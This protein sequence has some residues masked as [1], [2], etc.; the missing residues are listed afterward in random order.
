[1]KLDE[2]R[3]RFLAIAG[4][5]ATLSI[6]GCSSQDPNRE[7]TVDHQSTP[8]QTVTTGSDADVDSVTVALAIQPDQQRLRQQQSKLQSQIRN[9][10]VNRTTAQTKL[11]KLQS[12]LAAEATQK[13]VQSAKAGS[14]ITVKDSVAPLGVV[15]VSSSPP[16]VVNQLKN[17]RVQAIYSE[18]KFQQAKTRLGVR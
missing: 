15:L 12:Q 11:R 14:P 8:N 16:S 7:P 1:M 5:G 13:Y 17:E 2:E 6:A 18:K 3:R 4:S 9:G 10:T